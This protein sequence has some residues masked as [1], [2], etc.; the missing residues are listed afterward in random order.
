MTPIESTIPL[1]ERQVV[2]EVEGS[3]REGILEEKGPHRLSCLVSHR[4]SIRPRTAGPE[5]IGQ[6]GSR[7]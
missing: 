5:P 4:G 7:L 6:I 2:S 1:V 3:P